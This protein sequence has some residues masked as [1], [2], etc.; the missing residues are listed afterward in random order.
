MRIYE[1][2][3]AHVMSCMRNGI[4]EAYIE[5][6]FQNPIY[7]V[8]VD[9]AHWREYASEWL[10]K[11]SGYAELMIYG[12][13]DLLNPHDTGGWFACF[14]MLSDDKALPRDRSNPTTYIIEFNQ[15]VNNIKFYCQSK[16]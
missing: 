7:G 5:Y 9:L 3:N 2:H 6:E 11:N 10:D 13:Q 14:D 8:I 15:P 16:A 12:K 1:P 4:R